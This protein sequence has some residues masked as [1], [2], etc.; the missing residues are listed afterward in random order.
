MPRLRL[1]P[2]FKPE[3]PQQRREPKRTIC[4]DNNTQNQN[5]NNGLK[6][7]RRITDS[8]SQEC[9]NMN[10]HREEYQI[11]HR[12]PRRRRLTPL[13]MR[14]REAS[15]KLDDTELSHGL[16]RAVLLG[17]LRNELIAKSQDDSENIPAS[18]LGVELDGVMEDAAAIYE[19]FET[20]TFFATSPQSRPKSR[21]SNCT[22]AP[23]PTYSKTL[24]VP[25]QDEPRTCPTSPSSGN[26][27]W[28]PTQCAHHE[29]KTPPP[30]DIIT[31]PGRP[32]SKEPLSQ[33][34]ASSLA[35]GLFDMNVHLLTMS[36]GQESPATLETV[37]SP[38]EELA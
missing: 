23:T 28:D 21:L 5:E 3:I 11:L 13:H 29:V 26:A 12:C 10:C 19:G 4:L 38:K 34:V 37:W 17:N 25:E 15:Q 36:S 31:R 14:I 33:L 2:S 24:I 20:R 30:R 9:R 16:R 6:R 18:T 7:K 22:S 32:T 35:K 1:A 8:S 27:A